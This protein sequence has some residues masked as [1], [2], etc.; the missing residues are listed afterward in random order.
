M[1]YI[2]T[3]YCHEDL[4]IKESDYVVGV[5]LGA[6]QLFQNEVRID[7]AIGDFD[8][9]GKAD[10]EIVKKV[11]KKCIILDK[12]KDETDL[13]A[14]LKTFEF[15]S[16]ITIVG[17]LKGERSDHYFN[18]F[19]LLNKYNNLDAK[20]IDEKNEITLLKKGNHL[21]KKEDYK[22][23]SIFCLDSSIINVSD[24]FAYPLKDY[25]INLYSTNCIS[26]ELIKDDGYIEVLN[27]QVILVKCK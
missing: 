7:L 6:Y 2:V 11:S 23:F 12:N 9:I 13:E 1:I 22:Y 21:I 20:I 17:A 14:A 10:L 15:N 16:K 8:S 3:N 25:E 27:G 5:D 24:D 26:N 4:D 19:L 18:H